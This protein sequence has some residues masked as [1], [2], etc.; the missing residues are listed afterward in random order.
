MKNRAFTLIELLVV[1]LIIGMLAAIALPQYQKAVWKSKNAQ[2]KLLAKAYLDAQTSYY[3]ANGKYAKSF[4]DLDIQMPNWSSGSASSSS[5]FC[6]I[7]GTGED[8]SVRYNSKIQMTI[9]SGSMIIAWRS[10]PYRCGGFYVIHSNKEIMCTE[11][12]GESNAFAASSGDFCT[13]IEGAT[14]KDTPSTWRRYT[15]P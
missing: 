3:L 8:D 2:L 6:P 13:K 5:S 4:S 7:N 14:Y 10:G 11:R 1:V 15:M 9:M 12:G